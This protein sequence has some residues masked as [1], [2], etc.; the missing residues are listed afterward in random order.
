MPPRRAPP[1][2]SISRGAQIPKFIVGT[3]RMFSNWKYICSSEY[4]AWQQSLGN[5]PL[6]PPLTVPLQIVIT[7]GLF[8]NS[9]EFQEPLGGIIEP[10]WH[11]SSL[12]HAVRKDYVGTYLYFF[13][14]IMYLTSQSKVNRF[15]Y[16]RFL[17]T[18]NMNS[19]Y[20]CPAAYST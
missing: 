20:R 12:Y 9:R 19:I 5:Q 3:Y 6:D 13:I 14:H 8:W 16:K 10:H 11:C 2:R 7:G 15:Y 17:G 18:Q 1:N 4:V